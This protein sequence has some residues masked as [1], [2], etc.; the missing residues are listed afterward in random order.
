DLRDEGGQAPIGIDPINAAPINRPKPV[1][2]FDGELCLPKTARAD[3]NDFSRQDGCAVPKERI[4][5]VPEQVHPPDELLTK[6]TVRHAM[7]LWQR[8]DRRQLRSVSEGGIP[9]R[10]AAEL[11]ANPGVVGFKV[12]DGGHIDCL[13]LAEKAGKSGEVPTGP[14]HQR[15]Y[16]AF[17]P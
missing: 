7:S 15:P 1:C 14:Q 11:M 8:T 2:V 13:D 17:E 10:C 5:E 4:M 6:R 12:R 16:L 9:A 3:D